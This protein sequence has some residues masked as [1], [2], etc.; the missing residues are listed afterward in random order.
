MSQDDLNWIEH[1]GRH[2]IT[3]LGVP[4][5]AICYIVCR[6]GYGDRHSPYSHGDPDIAEHS[7]R[8]YIT[9]PADAD[10]FY[11]NHRND[12]VVKWA[13]A[14]WWLASHPEYTGLG[15][16]AA[17]PKPH[18]RHLSND[19]L[20]EMFSAAMIRS[21]ESLPEGTPTETALGVVAAEL[22]KAVRD[23]YETGYAGG[24]T[25]E[26]TPALTPKRKG[27]VIEL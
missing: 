25:I 9:V 7:D 17:P 3:E 18:P 23:H 20:G 13:L 15:V 5:H 8:Y 21:R 27:R 24:P 14:P 26:P 4:E 16:G 10:W 1:D 12:A 11:S 2:H 22:A 19:A 6:D